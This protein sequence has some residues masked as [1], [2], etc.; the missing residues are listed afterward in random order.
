MSESTA[1]LISI[2]GGLLIVL[3][4]YIKRRKYIKE[5][6]KKGIPVPPL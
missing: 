4:F 3:P 6:D 2:F 5:C 1:V